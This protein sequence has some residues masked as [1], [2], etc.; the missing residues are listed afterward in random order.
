M[1]SP[2]APTLLQEIRA[3]IL[4]QG[5]MRFRDFMEVALYH[6]TL[7]FYSSGRARIGREGDFFTSVSVGPLFGALIAHQI[8][9]IWRRL[10]RRAPFH[11]IEQGAHQGQLMGDVLQTL[12]NEHPECA[13]AIEVTIVEPSAPLQ[14]IQE[15]ALAHAAKRHRVQWVQSNTD[16]APFTGIHFSNELLDAFPVHRVVWNG[17]GW[18]ELYVDLGKDG[19]RFVPGPLS[20]PLLETFTNRVKGPYP[21]G[22]TTEVNIAAGAWAA[23]LVNKLETGCILAIDYGFSRDD[24]Y[25]PERSE[26]TLS[27]YSRHQRTGNPLLDPGDCD[28]TAHVDFTT[29]SEQAEACGARLLGF[30]DQHHFLVGLAPLHFLNSP[31]ANPRT[32]SETRAFKT[33]M[34]PAMMGS[35]FKAICLG[36][37][38]PELPPL[39]GF[40]H[41]QNSRSRLGLED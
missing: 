19:L 28:L 8:A 39:S 2:K 27:G 35:R 7:G 23:E 4:K 32:D 13:K 5:P 31:G 6:P 15:R 36:K 24:Y 30:T 11:L 37:N 3:A 29:L 38:L 9:E 18:E 34:H 20:V 40:T 25:R 22:D 1:H 10:E 41:A 26:G 12:E 21:A 33:L 17:R 16:L 14:A